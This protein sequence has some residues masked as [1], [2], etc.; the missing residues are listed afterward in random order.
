MELGKGLGRESH[1][2]QL[3][4]LGVGSRDELTGSLIALY[5]IT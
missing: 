2:E 4:E 5:N 3:R 1:E